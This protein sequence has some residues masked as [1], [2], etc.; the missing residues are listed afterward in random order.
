MTHSEVQRLYFMT[1]SR[2]VEDLDG[3]GGHLAAVFVEAPEPHGSLSHGVLLGS[4]HARWAML[5]GRPG[6][7]TGLLHQVPNRERKGARQGMFGERLGGTRPARLG[8]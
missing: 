1:N 8:D 4:T 2:G 6:R 7:Q 5:G 3:A